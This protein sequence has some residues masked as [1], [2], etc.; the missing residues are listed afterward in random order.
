MVSQC[1]LKFVLVRLFCPAYA[2]EQMRTH[3]NGAFQKVA[4]CL[5]RY[6][7]NSV[8][9]AR[10]ETGGKE[11]RRSLRT[12]DRASAQRALAW[13]KQE[14]QQV[15]PAQGKLTL[16]ELSDRY[17][18]TIQHQKPKTIERKALIARRIKSDWPTG[19]LTQVAKVKPS[20][21]D[22][23]VSRYSFWPVSR[24]QHI[25]EIKRIFDAAVRDGIIL[26]SPAAHLRKTKLSKPIRPTPSFEEFQAI[27]E[28][29]R[30]QKFNGHD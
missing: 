11:I 28:N 8:Y 18:A 4:E 25:A 13:L 7:S 10:F 1:G 19:R 16:G 27:V 5:Y 29:I 9:Y 20:H 2:Q 15:D 30:S 22:L 3:Q 12:T 21:V 6:S 23:W 14:Q 24:N 26:R 17:L